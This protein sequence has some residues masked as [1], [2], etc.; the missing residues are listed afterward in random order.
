MSHSRQRSATCWYCAASNVFVSQ[1][2]PARVTLAVSGQA[3]ETLPFPFPLIPGVDNPRG[4]H[5]VCKIP[6]SCTVK[7]HGIGNIR[8]SKS[9][10]D[11]LLPN[12][13]WLMQY[14]RTQSSSSMAPSERSMYSSSSTAS[15]PSSLLALPSVTH[16]L[17]SLPT[18]SS[19]PNDMLH[20]NSGA[21][22]KARMEYALQKQKQQ[23]ASHTSYAALNA[24]DVRRTP[25]PSF[26]EDAQITVRR[27]QNSRQYNSRD[28]R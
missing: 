15:P 20:Y 2:G 3:L 4:S 19:V 22:S 7:Q 8:C 11:V 17:A 5:H 1:N 9:Q 16:S 12:N 23:A 25:S 10:Q 14:Q 6:I 28:R 26:N 27:Q 24:Y 21:H 13:K 18:M